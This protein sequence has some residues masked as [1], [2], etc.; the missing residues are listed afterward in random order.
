MTVVELMAMLASCEG[1]IVAPPDQAQRLVGALRAM[2][3]DDWACFVE[4]M[5][6]LPQQKTQSFAIGG[7]ADMAYCTAHVRL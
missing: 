6:D 4:F 1:I 7:K 3:A 5:H 2:T